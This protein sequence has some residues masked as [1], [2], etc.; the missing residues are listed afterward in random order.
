MNIKTTINKIPNSRELEKRLL[1]YAQI[2]YFMNYDEEAYKVYHHDDKDWIPGGHYF[3]IDDT[4]G[5]HYHVL[6]SPAGSVIKGFGHE[7]E[8][9]PYNFEDD[10]LPELIK[11]HDFYQGM[12]E[13]LFALIDDDALEKELA[14]FCVWQKAG[15]EGWT[16]APID[17]PADWA[18][19]SAYFLEYV[20]DLQRYG[21]WFEGYYEEPI[22]GDVL[23]LLY[24][25][26]PV[27]KGMIEKLPT[28]QDAEELLRDY[29]QN[30]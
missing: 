7:T 11:N 28:E 23:D 1:T 20:F 21:I 4:G 14:T 5:D 30:F 19:G 3:R 2:D 24:N 6:I 10:D 26:V 22:D 27:T 9:S 13:E 18:D 8:M 25:G 17:I 15:E 16:C 12:P 29:A